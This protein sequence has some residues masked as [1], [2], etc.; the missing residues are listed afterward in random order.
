MAERAGNKA[1]TDAIVRGR[2][3][4][5]GPAVGSLSRQTKPPALMNH[6]GLVFFFAFP[7]SPRELSKKTGHT[8]QS[9]Q[10][11]SFPLTFLC[12]LEAKVVPMLMAWGVRRVP[13]LPQV[14][15]RCRMDSSAHFPAENTVFFSAVEMSQTTGAG[16]TQLTFNC[17]HS[18][19]R[20]L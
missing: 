12:P 10:A 2:G 7:P 1:H 14:L 15:V 5:P 16:C 4:V 8:E 11:G 18:L 13:L 3:A 6:F 9:Q 19:R 17:F 20:T